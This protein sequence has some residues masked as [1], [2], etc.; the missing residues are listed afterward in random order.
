MKFSKLLV[1]A[2]SILAFALPVLGQLPTGT[3][4]GHVDDGTVAV[5]GVTVTVASA[6]LQGTR[7]AATSVNGDYIFNFLPPGDYVVKFELQGFQTV[8]TGVKIS[9]AQRATVDATMPQATV[10]EEVTVTGSYETI[11][12]SSQAAMTITQNLLNKL[13]IAQTFYNYAALAP[14]TASTGPSQNLTIS[15]AQSWEN[16][17]MVNGVS[18]QDNVRN[19]PT[20]LFI[21]DAIQETTT[22]T[23][24]VSAE[25]GR[26]AGGVVNMLTKSGGN[27]MHGSARLNL[28]SSKWAEKAPLRT[29]ILNDTIDRTWMATLGGFVVKDKLWYFLGYRNRSTEA[30][31]QTYI[32][33]LPYTQPIEESRYEGKLTFSI[34]PNH[35]IIGSYIKNEQ[36]QGN[37]FFGFPMD[38]ASLYNR[39]LPT[40]LTAG[41]YT[42]ILSD[43]LFVEAQY[44]RKK[45]AF[46]G[47]GSLYT[48]LIKGTL[49]IDLSRG[50]SYRYWSPTFC[51]VCDPET[52]DNEEYLVKGSYFL[53][54]PGLGTHDIVAGY[55]SFNDQRFSNNHQSGSDY[56]IRGSSTII[57]G[58][59]IYPQWFN[60]NTVV[61]WTPIFAGS[62]GTNFKTNS[63]FVNDK[64]RLNNHWSFNIGLRYDKNDGKDSDGKLVAKDSAV[65]PRLG[66]TWDPKGDGEWLF[67]ASYGKY[68]MAIASGIADGTAVGGQPGT[69]D[70]AYKGPEINPN[71]NAATLLDSAAALQILFDWYHANVDENDFA[72]NPYLL[73]ADIPGA[74]A[75]IKD[76]LNS[77]SADEITLGVTKRFG[78]RG[79]VRVDF[80]NR[81][82]HDF[83]DLQR[84]LSTGQITT[85]NGT[86]DKGYYVNNDSSLE[87]RYRAIQVQFS[88]RPW[89]ALSIGGNYTY[90]NAYGNVDGENTVSG[91]ITSGI[92]TYP[93]YLRAAWYAPKGDLAIDQ[94]HKARLWVVYDIFNTKHNSLSVSLLQSFFSGTPYGAIGTINLVSGGVPYVT[95]PGYKVPPTL[96]TYYF[97]N[98]D[99]FHTDDETRTDISF[100]Y[101]FKVP[102]LGAQIEFFVIPGVTNVFNEKA[103]ELPNASVYTSRNSGRGLSNFNPFT[104]E[105][106]ECP[107]GNT[108]AQ[109]TA[110]GANWQKAPTFGN[111][112]AYQNYQ[113]ARTFTLSVGVRF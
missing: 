88:Y 63:V 82:F 19:T 21:E 100:N 80:V 112:V 101:G 14:G 64:W 71:S 106:I 1:C 66:T 55:D 99:T 69:I 33:N 32:T 91:P 30:S 36:T 6:N 73:G 12:T 108:A 9:A 74:T 7:T 57:R 70:F 35:R 96:Q 97:T 38:F 78:T 39:E 44:S 59:E 84:D 46:V 86:F 61:R 111:A 56:R 49:L 81:T 27:E 22:Q 93:E 28:D 65:S 24:A 25:Y 47:S 34:N 72:T 76:S 103:V 4:T 20:N 2:V 13:P 42:G 107:Q 75:Q 15:G 54:T 52:R 45:F 77:T 53:S 5:P 43:N 51:G 87:R 105:P 92:L 50:N 83:Y 40:D 58:G 113:T 16:L 29:G 95:N 79:L 17:F 62:K 48:D 89:D 26:F 102:A 31:T 67:N 41:N 110:L 11:S 104:T 18:I 37:N 94:Q 90:S 98:R 23:A 60:T 109:C 3:L 10:A 68:T 85:P 8:E